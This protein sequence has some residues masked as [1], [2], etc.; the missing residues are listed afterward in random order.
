VRDAKNDKNKKVADHKSDTFFM[1]DAAL[2]FYAGT[3][4]C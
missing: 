1:F 2:I 3:F 4:L